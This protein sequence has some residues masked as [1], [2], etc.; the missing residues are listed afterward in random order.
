MPT[1]NNVPADRPE[2]GFSA[3]QP[4]LVRLE[5]YEGPL[6]ALLDLVKRQEINILDIPITRITEQYLESLRRAETL[7]FELSAEFVLM[8]STLIHIKSKMLLPVTPTVDEEPEDPRDDLVRNLVE[9]EKFLQAAQI[10]KEKRVIEEN[11]WTATTQESLAAESEEQDE[12][13]VTL[14]DLVKTFG[15]VLERLKNEPVVE[16]SQE[17]VSVADRI[18]FLRNLL[19]SQDGE[20]RVSEILERQT[21]PRAVIATFLAL[22]E[23]V[24]AQAVTL[25]QADLFGEIVIRKHGRFDEALQS[26]EL[27]PSASAD[28]E[29]S[30]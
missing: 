2:S 26:G 11:V 15:D 16:F 5:Q 7:N 23:M 4:F 3:E 28:L 24:R 6:D 8:A 30:V 21:S 17:Q 9:R 13:Q 19:V 10:L 29:Y 20:V 18:R 12:L 1:P 14:F 22:L 25:R 27:I